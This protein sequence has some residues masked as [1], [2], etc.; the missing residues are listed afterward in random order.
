M[1]EKKPLVVCVT[2]AAGQIGYAI[3][4]MICNGDMF[5][6]DQPIILHLLDLPFC[7]ESL[8]GVV[9]E[10]ED[11]NYPLV[12]GVVATSDVGKAFSGADCAVLLGAFPRKQG[13][14]RKELMEKNIGIFKAM[15]EAVEKN[16][17]PNIKVLVVGNPANTNALIMSNYAPKVPKANFTAMTRL[18][19]HRA[20]GQIALKV[21]C[22]VKDVQNVIIWGN[23]SSTQYPDVNHATVQGKPV[24]QAL[25]N[26]AYL[27]GEFIETIQKRG[28]AIINA[29]KA[30]SALS[31]ARAAVTHMRSWFC[32]TA[33]GEYV[34]MGVLSDSNSYGVKRG[35]MYSFPC[36]CK[37]G[38]WSIV[39][40]LKCDQFS[41]AKMKVT[42]DELQE[43]KDLAFSLL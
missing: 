30:S 38:Q 7:M 20:L 9:M 19:H 18:D 17:S 4:P 34:S 24:R 22:S 25:A 13:M 14:E 2:G 6:K 36:S 35:L 11:G 41:Q 43:E 21:G 37:D 26:D 10:I 32:G 16:A 27:N 23:H 29:R 15:G 8:G 42:E 5:G 3:T 39:D 12:Y 28:A 1:A 40:G 33:P 31:A